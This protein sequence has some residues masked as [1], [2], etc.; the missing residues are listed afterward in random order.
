MPA[1]NAVL[2]ALTVCRKNGGW[3]DAVLKEEIKNARLSQRDAAFATALFY[4]ILQNQAL[5]DYEINLLLTGRKHLQ[6]VLRDILRLAIYQLQFMNRVPDSAA[7]HEAVE[8]AKKKFSLREAGLCN[9]VLRNFLRKKDTL[10]LPEDYAIRYSHPAELVNLIR[11]SV[12]EKLEPILRADNSSPETTVIVNSLKTTP[13]R[14]AHSL[15]ETGVS[16]TPHPWLS[17]CFLLRGTGNLEQLP[18]FREG[19][20]QVQDA[21]ARLAVDVLAP[22]PGENVLDLC[23]AP[24]GKSMAAAMHMKNQGTILACDIHRGKL[25]EI[26]K[27]ASRLGVSIVETVEN[28][29]LEFRR[30]WEKQFD[31]VIADVP[32]SGLGVIRKKPDIRYKNVKAIETL[33]ALQKEILAQ[34]GRY[35]RPGG[36]LL[37]STC[38]IL[39][40]ENEMVAE[41]FFKQ[42]P[43]FS[44]VPFSVPEPLS[45]QST[46]MLSLYQGLDDCDGFF[47]SVMRKQQ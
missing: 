20:F 31:I 33:P 17:G 36:R 21:A 12:G 13:K 22:Q 3:S 40:R 11:E 10:E 41:G 46:G 2:R 35:V 1:R 30:T 29:A 23:A 26:Q 34:A 8:Q 47:L 39:Q 9:A 27:A 42:H 32:C 19:L 24:G 7:V 16:V 44:A 15:A 5:L 4:G 38:T 37:Y 18:A 28:D 6:P 25:E 43:E 45:C 14:L